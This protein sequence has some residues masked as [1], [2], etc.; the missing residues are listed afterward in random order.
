MTGA[1]ERV[2]ISGA[3]LIT[4]MSRRTLQDLAPS[5]PGAS[6]PAG[7]WLFVVSELRAWVTRTTR[8]TSCRKTYT[9]EKEYTGRG[10][11][12]AARNTDKAYEHVLSGSR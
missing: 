11:R 2:G 3:V 8:R 7:R 10:S 4:G 1:P 9:F 6:K 5:I 12:S